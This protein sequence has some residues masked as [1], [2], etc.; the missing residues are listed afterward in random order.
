MPGGTCGPSRFPVPCRLPVRC[1]CGCGW[2][3]GDLRVGSALS[4]RHPE[5]QLAVELVLEYAAVRLYH[6][7]G[8]EV[9][10]VAGDQRR[11]DPARGSLRK[12][13]AQ[14][15]GRGRDGGQPAGRRNRCARSRG[16]AARS[17]C[18]AAQSD[19]D[20][21]RS[22]AT[23]MSCRAPNL[24]AVAPSRALRRGRI[25]RTPRSPRPYATFRVDGPR[26]VYRLSAQA[27]RR[28][29]RMAG[30]VP[31]NVGRE[32]RLARESPRLGGRCDSAP[33]GSGNWAADRNN[34]TPLMT[35]IT[36]KAPKITISATPRKADRP[37]MPR[38]Q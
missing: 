4:G 5:A 30:A 2:L 3:C 7:R 32:S 37:T 24:P 18:A 16:V 15:R 19:P 22:R 29:C 27:F 13:G 21:R 17:A 9:V 6:L 10:H 23:T 25:V 36:A 1:G 26:R 14:H 31:T 35:K 38:G 12:H 33:A 34:C 8:C 28:C 11:G 20:N